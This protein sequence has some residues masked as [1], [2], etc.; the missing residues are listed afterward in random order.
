MA[1]LTIREKNQVTVPSRVLEKT[2]LKTGDPIEFD[3]LP[4]G[5]IGI[6]PLGH[7]D[8]CRSLWDVAEE[9]AAR[10]PGIEDIELELP[11]RVV[12]EP[13]EIEW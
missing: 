11:P 9:I 10:F 12:E 1:V 6:Y 2:A 8:Q 13:R 7:R 3:V 4:D 5:G